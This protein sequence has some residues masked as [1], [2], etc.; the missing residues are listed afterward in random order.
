MNAFSVGDKIQVIISNIKK[1]NLNIGNAVNNKVGIITEINEHKLSPLQEGEAE[2]R[3]QPTEE[4]VEYLVKFD[5]P[6]IPQKGC[7]I[8]REFN[9]FWFRSCDLKSQ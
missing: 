4:D 8:N 5:V 1:W 6:A 2:Y 7:Y 3:K 9:N